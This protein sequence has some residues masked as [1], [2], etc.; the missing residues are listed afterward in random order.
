MKN[1]T[2][3]QQI[4]FDYIN[5]VNITGSWENENKYFYCECGSYKP[6]N[7]KTVDSLVKKGIVKILEGSSPCDGVYLLTT[8]N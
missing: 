1:L 7:E 5:Q 4:L 6:F 8:N 3:K 2:Q